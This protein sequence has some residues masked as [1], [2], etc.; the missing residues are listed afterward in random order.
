V[1]HLKLS[2]ADG[3]EEILPL[4]GERLLVGRSRECDLVLPDVLLSRRH[5]ELYRTARGWLVR[6]L[7]SM[8]G[9]RV[10]DARIDHERVLYDGDVVGVA[11]W[12]LAFFEADPAQGDT[13]TSDHQ[14]RVHDI[15]SL[16]TQSGL[17]LSDLTRQGRLLGVLTRAAGA[18]VASTD[19][20]ALLDTLLTHLLDAVPA[21]R[22]AVAFLDRDP[23][24]PAVSAA[25]PGEAKAPVTI[26]AGVA[27]RVLGGRSALLAPRVPAEDETVRSVVCAPIWFTGPGEGTDRVVGLVYLEAPAEPNPF[28]TEHLGLVSAIVNLAASR[29]ESVRLREETAEKRRLEEDL[30]GAARIQA[31]LLPEEEPSLEGWDVGG[32]SR[33]CSAVGADYYDFTVDHGELLLALGDVAGKGLAAALLMAAL[34]AAVRA[35]WVEPESLPRMLAR[36]NENLLQT[37]PPNRFAT[38]VLARLQPTTGELRYVNAGHAAPILIRADG[39][40]ERLEDGGTILGIL[41][42]ATWEEGRASL[43][44]G[45]TFV[46]LSDGV[47]EVPGAGL[48]GEAVAAEVRRAGG[49]GVPEILSALQSAADEALG[50]QQNDDDHTFVVLRR[51]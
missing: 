2:S 51:L 8:N 43:A 10:N 40:A 30:R 1:P 17:D 13:P 6:D 31:S 26:D 41:P 9:T 37:L 19:A 27:E 50:R 46:G 25:R 22:G 23:L 4:R 48:A 47:V 44:P 5:A 18:I 21:Q 7:G 29:L 35:L 33:L 42:G 24:A 38:L 16:A 3:P 11:G 36:I 14:A 34:R 39:R 45:D 49:R 15:T 12:R 32:S 28:A 20:D